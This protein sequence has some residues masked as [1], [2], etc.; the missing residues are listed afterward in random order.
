M[1][2]KKRMSKMLA[3]VL[4]AVTVF[5]AIFGVLPVEAEQSASSIYSS[6]FNQA[7]DF[8]DL[9]VGTKITADYL[10]GKSEGDFTS[11][12]EGGSSNSPTKWQVYDDP[13]DT[14]NRVIGLVNRS[15]YGLFSLR[16]EDMLLYDG[17]FEAAW[18]FCLNAE[19]KTTTMLGLYSAENTRISLLRINK[20]KLGYKNE[21]G[22]D[23]WTDLEGNSR[24]L[25]YGRWYDLRV[26]VFPNTGRVVVYVD[27]EKA[28]DFVLADLKNAAPTYAGLNFCYGWSGVT[29]D[30][31]LDDISVRSVDEKAFEKL[32]AEEAK[33]DDMLS[34][35][36][37]I[38]E[39]K[40]YR[41]AFTYL[42]NDGKLGI[43]VAL[44]TYYKG[45]N[46]TAETPVILYVM[47]YV[48]AGEV[49]TEDNG[50]ILA[51]LLD[52]GYIVLTV[53]YC[54]NAAAVSPTLDWSIQNIRMTVKN[55]LGGLSCHSI[56]R[57]VVP[58]GYRIARNIVYYNIDI[59]ARKGT[60]EKIIRDYNDPTGSFRKAKLSKIPNPDETVTSIDRCLKPDGTPIDLQLKMDIIYPSGG[61][62]SVPVVMVSSSSETRMKVCATNANRPLD[63]GGLLRGCAVAIYDHA[64]VPMARDDHYGYYSS[65]SLMWTG[66]INSHASAVRCVR[67]YADT[68]GYSKENYAVMGHSKASQCGVLANEHPELLENWQSVPEGY[69]SDECYGEQ[70]FLAYEDGTPIPSNVSV[71][72][73][74]MGDGSKYHMKFLDADNA[75]TMICCGIKY[76]Y[77]AWDYWEQ[78]ML[79]YEKSGIEY[80]PITMTNLGH[81]YPYGIDPEYNY[82]R[83]AAFMDFLMYY[84]KK[85]QAPRIL[86]S[87]V[88]NGK[89]M[90]DVVITRYTKEGS[91]KAYGS[92]TV[93]TGDELF[94]QFL[95]PVT[96]ASA[97]GGIH[98]WDVTEN[99][100]V[101]G[102]L[103]AMGNG[104]KWYFLPK[105]DLVEGHTYEL[106]L[107]SSVKSVLNGV[108]IGEDAVYQFVA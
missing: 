81:D 74:S 79:N 63:V 76:G 60:I 6:T 36:Y 28:F 31:F 64:Y 40:Q 70:A 101:E 46:S 2:A 7:Y 4:A 50:T 80:L 11:F 8:N 69:A 12:P 1:K 18:R 38:E 68:F 9:D 100:E 26:M 52:E 57:Y 56:E 89:V 49:G 33:K 15:S 72:Y 91:T 21:N 20:N 77:G 42:G 98:L 53:D 99:R 5:P 95:A 104:N 54:D 67:Y 96:E 22:N 35:N 43:P 10:N 105:G 103:Q 82:D 94:V 73:H 58:E 83:Y 39:V 13:A 84:L 61:D 16:D 29:F 71:A 41:K 62:A 75:P 44:T 17:A 102:A 3:A 55:Y 66:T 23:K 93:K 85:D 34:D 78:E 24:V 106:R 88:V 27:S 86:Y 45:E 65:Y 30:A 14:G 32:E 108:S 59:N 48:G 97:K 37:V 47:G 25:E 92:H 51:D 87:S 90:G 19:T 107:D